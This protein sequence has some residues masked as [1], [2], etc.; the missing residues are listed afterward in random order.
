MKTTPLMGW[1]KKYSQRKWSERK[2][3]EEEGKEKKE[4]RRKRW[5][6]S[7]LNVTTDEGSSEKKRA[8]SS[9]Q[10]TSAPL[11]LLPPSLSL[12]RSHERSGG[13]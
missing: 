7:E 8:Q 1:R 9:I 11:P 5:R 13:R 10:M 3:E 6:E 4:R 12:L 2:K